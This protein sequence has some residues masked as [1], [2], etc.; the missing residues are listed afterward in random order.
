MAVAGGIIDQDYRG[1]II[2]M[3]TNTSR[4]TYK[5]VTRQK[6]AQ[7]IVIPCSNAPVIQVPSLSQ[8]KRGSGGLGRQTPSP[9]P[10]LISAAMG[11]TAQG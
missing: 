6:I 9:R 11:L 5:V 1:E 10:Q 8:T 3:L 7:L 4:S 2:V